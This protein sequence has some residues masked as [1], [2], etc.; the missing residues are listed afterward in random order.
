MIMENRKYGALEGPY[1]CQMPDDERPTR[2]LILL[3]GWGADGHDLAELSAALHQMMPDLACWFPHAPSPCSA[4]PM[5]RQWFE[6]SERFYQDPAASLPEMEEAAYIIESAI[7]EICDDLSLMSQDVILGG[8]SQ[9]GMMTLHIATNQRLEAAGFA[10]L[11]G[12]L[13]GQVEPV[14]SSEATIFL[15]HG[16]QDQVVPFAASKQA[17]T[18]LEDAGYQ[19]ELMA[20]ADLGHGIDM[21]VL[22]GLGRY[23]HQV[24]A[25]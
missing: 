18:D 11:S 7:G 6:I 3:H 12:A 21:A 9:G 20:R 1:S 13:I 17:Q 19:V 24:T 8:F 14:S 10:S 16:Q 5:G 2:L 4:N 23:C 22:E 25:S 15:A